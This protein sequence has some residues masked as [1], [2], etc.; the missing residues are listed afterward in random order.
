[1]DNIDITK[2]KINV[3][4]YYR[5]P[6]DIVTIYHDL[7][8]FTTLIPISTGFRTGN[9][10]QI[11]FNVFRQSENEYFLKYCTSGIG[12]FECQGKR[13]VIHAGDLIL[14]NKSVSHS[15]GTSDV[16]PWS[17]YWTYFQ[18]NYMK[19]LYPKLL[20][21]N[22]LI[23]KL[24]Y[25]SL[26]IRYFK[27]ILQSKSNGYALPYLFH[28]A[29]NLGL[30]I[31]HVNMYQISAFNAPEPNYASIINYMNQ[32]LHLPLDLPSIAKANGLSK[33]HFIRLFFSSYGY[34][35]HDYFLRLKIQKAC[36]YLLT[37]DWTIKKIASSLGYDDPYY[38]SRLF[39]KK[40]GVSP[41]QYRSMI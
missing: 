24:G 36:N 5:V 31:A 18:S 37:T 14:C 22:Y 13:Q 8:L 35:P 15:Y 41:T 40:I 6:E 33:D 27:D 21:Q 32:Q 2:E 3:S 29:Q 39:K 34:T 38:F 4:F 12:W 11:G 7:P 9:N 16:N 1:M 23:F 28:A 25:D 19:Y 20:E 26:L 30:L 17:A 10:K